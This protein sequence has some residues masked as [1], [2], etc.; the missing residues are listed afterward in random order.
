M[1]LTIQGLAS[2]YY[3]HYEKGT[4]SIESFNYFTAKDLIFDKHFSFPS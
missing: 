4:R 3:D 1:I 2:Y